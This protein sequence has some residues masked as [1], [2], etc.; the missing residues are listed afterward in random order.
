MQTHSIGAVHCARRKA[1]HHICQGVQRLQKIKAPTSK[2]VGPSDANPSASPRSRDNQSNLHLADD[3]IIAVCP[4]PSLGPYLLVWHVTPH[5]NVT[6]QLGAETVPG[7]T[8]C[9][10]TVTSAGARSDSRI[11]LRR[12]HECHASH[13][14]HGASVFSVYTPAA[15]CAAVMFQ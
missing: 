8:C 11:P 1:F 5:Y 9:T 14:L 13:V 7:D 4:L 15:P 3:I 2:R 6:N 12:S 10:G